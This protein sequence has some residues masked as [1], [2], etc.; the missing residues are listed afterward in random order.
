MTG[1]RAK[2]TRIR[3]ANEYQMK[4][5]GGLTQTSVNTPALIYLSPTDIPSCLIFCSST[6]RL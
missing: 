6:T 5:A 1:T 3:S 4:E 2:I